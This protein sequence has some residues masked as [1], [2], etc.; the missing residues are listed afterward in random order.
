MELKG[1]LK[2]ETAPY[3]PS[4]TSP[5]LVHVSLTSTCH[6]D[7]KNNTYPNP[8]DDQ[9]HSPY[10]T[11][12]RKPCRRTYPFPRSKKLVSTIPWLWFRESLGQ[13]KPF[14]SCVCVCR[15]KHVLDSWQ[16]NYYLVQLITPAWLHSQA[17]CTQYVWQLTKALSILIK[18]FNSG[19]SCFYDKLF[20]FN[21]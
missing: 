1:F 2:T 17:Y 21:I 14:Y 8:Q 18:I 9:V 7:T 4:M 15:S 5:L 16:L 13:I 11:H 12:T 3:I 20:D 10:T 6:N 19:L